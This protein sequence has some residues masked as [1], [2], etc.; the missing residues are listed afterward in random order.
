[1]DSAESLSHHISSRFNA[2]LEQIRSEVL[3]MGGLVEQQLQRAM[4]VLARGAS[5]EADLVER[6][7]Q[8]VD[9]MERSI[10]GDCS[11]IL[12]TR[13]PAASDLRLMVGILKLITDLERMGDEAQKMARI[14]ARL[15][16]Q[17]NAVARPQQLRNLGV[18]VVSMV[19][20]ALDAFARL[21]SE[22]AEAVMR[23]DRDVDEEYEALHRQSIT[24][25]MEDPRTIRRSL[26]L[27]WLIRSLERVGDHAKNVCEHVIYMVRGVDVRHSAG[28]REAKE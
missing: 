21:D 23:R 20:D 7:E 9:A 2:D 27:M 3:A 8:R 4:S 14:G 11:R 5:E 15:V 18:L 16:R 12:A 6:D 22:S 19:H 26:D 13:A 24:F 25:M 1:M 28:A 17:G 10:D